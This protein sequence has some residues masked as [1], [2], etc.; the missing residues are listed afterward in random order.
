VLRR[1]LDFS[2]REKGNDHEETLAHLLTLAVHLENVGQLADASA[3]DEIATRVGAK[4]K[5]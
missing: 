3:H 2:R 4:K 1:R 5:E